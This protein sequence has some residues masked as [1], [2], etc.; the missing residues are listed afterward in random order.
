M[1]LSVVPTQASELKVGHYIC[2]N[3]RPC[4]ITDLTDSKTGKHGGR[5]IHFF[6]TD[7]FNE[8]KYE[9]CIMSKQHADSPVVTKT[10]YQLM[11]IDEKNVVS[12]L[13]ENMIE[14]TDLFLPHSCEDDLEL[15][16]QIKKHFENNDE[17]YISV[18]SAMDIREIKGFRIQNI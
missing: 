11:D 10:E 13:D 17:I 18:I 12:Y 14:Q 16:E 8:K 1:S 7:L 5:K 2:I 9:H 4:K 3:D 15:A 6:T